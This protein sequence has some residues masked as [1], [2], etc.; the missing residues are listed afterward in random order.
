MLYGLQVSK[1]KEIVDLLKISGTEGMSRY[2]LIKHVIQYLD[3][4]VAKQEDG[5]LAIFDAVLQQ[6]KSDKSP[7]PKS[8]PPGSSTG[9]KML[10]IRSS[11]AKRDLKINGQIGAT[12]QTDRLSCKSCNLKLLHKEFADLDC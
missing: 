6:G 2:Q 3:S 8:S 5:G 10:E 9:A 4:H 1:V 7:P 11:F 12:A